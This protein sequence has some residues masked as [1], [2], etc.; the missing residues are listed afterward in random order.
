MEDQ[1][2]HEEPESRKKFVFVS[3]DRPFDDEK[4]NLRSLITLLGHL[5][6][7]GLDH[8]WPFRTAFILCELTVM[9]FVT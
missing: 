8:L 2:L 3:S 7:A 4:E 1:T 6:S 5:V 9:S